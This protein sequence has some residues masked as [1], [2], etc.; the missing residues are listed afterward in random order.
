MVLPPL[1]APEAERQQALMSG[2]GRFLIGFGRDVGEPGQGLWRSMPDGQRVLALHLTSPGAAG[3][4]LGLRVANLPHA[5]LLRFSGT[6][7]ADVVEIPGAEVNASLTA[8]GAGASEMD[9]SALFW[10]PLLQGGTN[11]LEVVLPAG[12]SANAIE[13]V[14][15]RVSHI[16]RLPFVATAPE[17]ALEPCHA[18]VACDDGW[19]AVSRAT[20]LLLFTDD[21]GDTGGCTG[22]LL[23]DADPDTDIPYLLTAHHCISGQ[24]EASSIETVWFYRAGGCD[25]GPESSEIVRGGADLLYAAKTTDTSFMRLRRPAPAGAVFAAWSTRLPVEGEPVVGIHHP[26]G[27]RQKLAHGLLK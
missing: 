10:T 4:R 7:A 20:T 13:V 9:K 5:A 24:P 17:P 11:S 6:W 23:R 19:D 25:A 3:L 8:D 16:F 26:R 1:S 22:T 12:A 21:T 2:D 27:D 18:D 15:E 14:P